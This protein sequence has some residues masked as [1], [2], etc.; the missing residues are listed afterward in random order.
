MIS[1]EEPYSEHTVY[2]GC[3][4][5]HTG[6]LIYKQFFSVIILHVFS[7]CVIIFEMCKL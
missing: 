1:D 4:I 5:F 6:P 7:L 3:N 2:V